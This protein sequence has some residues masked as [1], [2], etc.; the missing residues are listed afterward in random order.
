MDPTHVE[1]MPMCSFVV[2]MRFWLITVR[3]KI[4]VIFLY[5]PSR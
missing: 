3:T 5:I 4:H 2:L 1:L